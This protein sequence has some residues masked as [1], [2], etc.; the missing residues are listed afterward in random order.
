MFESPHM[1]QIKHRKNSK[2]LWANNKRNEQ[3]NS[4]WD[5][6]DDININ[7]SRCVVFHS[8]T[9]GVVCVSVYVCVYV[10]ALSIS[11]RDACEIH[12]NNM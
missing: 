8:H 12:A 5:L 3:Y 11:C 10:S 1:Q 9:F 2:K 6:N 4:N 7:G